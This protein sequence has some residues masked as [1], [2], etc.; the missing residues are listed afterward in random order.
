[1]A[2]MACTAYP[3]D[4]LSL[5]SDLTASHPGDIVVELTLKTLK[6]QRSEYLVH[7]GVVKVQRE[8]R[9]RNRHGSCCFK[10]HAVR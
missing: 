5:T 2:R 7:Q 8:V 9:C 1:M 3:V 10:A 6:S 4:V